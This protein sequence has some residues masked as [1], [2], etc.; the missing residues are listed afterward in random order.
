MSDTYRAD[1][2]RAL[3]PPQTQRSSPRSWLPDRPPKTVLAH[4]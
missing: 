1:A 2:G 4:A 3:D